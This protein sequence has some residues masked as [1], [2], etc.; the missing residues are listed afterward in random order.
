MERALSRGLGLAAVFLG[1]GL[2]V[3]PGLPLDSRVIGIGGVDHL[4]TLWTWRQAALALQGDVSRL[5]QAPDLYFPYGM[6]LYRNTGGNVLDGLLAAPLSWLGFPLGHNLALLAVLVANGLAAARIAPGPAAQPEA[7]WLAG[8]AGA[9]ASFPLFELVE[10]RPTQALLAP[11]WLAAS[12]ILRL[13]AQAGH[14]AVARAGLGMAL[15]GLF[16]WYYGLFVGLFAVALGIA[17]SLRP[18]TRPSG[19]RVLAAA[20][21]GGALVL[22]LLGPLLLDLARGAVPGLRVEGD[23]AYVLASLDPLSGM[24]TARQ[25]NE[26]VGRYPGFPAWG[27]IA[28]AAALA[29]SATRL[30]RAVLLVLGLSIAVGP[31]IRVGGASVASPAWWLWSALVPPLERLWHPSRALVLVLPLVIWGLGELP[32]WARPVVTA[33]LLAAPWRAGALPLPTW[34]AVP[35]AVDVCLS[36]GGREAVIDLPFAASQRN[37]WSQVIHGRPVAGGMHE[38]APAFQ[39]EEARALRAENALLR[40]MLTGEDDTVE[41]ATASAELVAL[42]FGFVVLRLDELDEA[43]TD[44]LRRARRREAKRALE[45]LLGPP[46]WDDARAVAWSLGGLPLPCVGR[47]PPADT[48][49]ADRLRDRWLAP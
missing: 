30:P 35:A 10:G 4:G 45:G 39:P 24:V 49:P 5:I 37:L 13:P 32:R 19:L 43:P 7:R 38:G 22:P 1:A 12:A 3:G 20:G 26:V 31:A 33:A 9:T 2:V 27:W 21:V 15:A 8:L 14:A 29:P 48:V 34:S 17:W 47:E 46:V 18:A 6:D 44:A 16:Y 23:G 11:A 42:G 41:L 40:G 25:G 36:E 28:V